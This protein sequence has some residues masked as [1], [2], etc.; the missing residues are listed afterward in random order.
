M[1]SSFG[2]QR[3]GN[4]KNTPSPT[5][6]NSKRVVEWKNM[7][8]GWV[9]VSLGWHFEVTALLWAIAIPWRGPK[10]WQRESGW[11][12][13]GGRGI[14]AWK[15]A[16]EKKKGARDAEIQQERKGEED[17][18][19][20]MRNNKWPPWPS[21]APPTPSLYITDLWVWKLI[22]CCGCWWWHFENGN[23]QPH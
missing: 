14:K 4:T 20:L 18:S 12:K 8:D 10:M 3:C 13:G 17:W 21:S 2:G 7:K 19:I 16:E 15:R 22:Y 1:C 6:L 9:L 5:Q 23:T 11:G